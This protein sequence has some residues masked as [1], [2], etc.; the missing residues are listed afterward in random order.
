M[1]SVSDAGSSTV[2]EQ[3]KAD[4][5]SGSEGSCME[6]DTL[7]NVD[8][9]KHMETDR[10]HC[11]SSLADSH[12]QVETESSM[13]QL[14]Y[15]GISWDDASTDFVECFVHEVHLNREQCLVLVHCMSRVE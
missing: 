15:T 9:M 5:L 10:L 2:H 4:Q 13:L 8:H 11:L 12:A 14:E 6:Y 3:Y 1:A 7:A